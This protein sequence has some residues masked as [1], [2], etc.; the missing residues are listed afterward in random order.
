MWLA[1]VKDIIRLE[2]PKHSLAEAVQ[3]DLSASPRV[4]VL[5]STYQGALYV[6]E[7]L[8]SVLM[9]L[10]AQGTIV[11]R[12]DGS[13]DATVAE[14]AKIADPRIKVILGQNLGFGQSFLT[15]LTLVPEDVDMVMFADQDDV[16]LSNKIARAWEGVRSVGDVPALYGSAQTLVDRHLKSLHV[17]TTPSR[18]PSLANALTENII[19]GCTA[20]INRP[21]F[22]LL[23]RAGVPTGVQFHDWWLYL[24]VSAFGIVVYDD[25]PTLLYRQHGANVIGRRVGWRGHLQG[26][27]KVVTRNDWLGVLL[28]QV[29]AFVEHYGDSLP[30]GI[31]AWIAQHFERHGGETVPRWTLVFSTQRWRQS[32]ADDLALR[33]LLLLHKCGWAAGGK[34]ATGGVSASGPMG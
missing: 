9:Q 32:L 29:H 2:K 26:A 10:P 19:V 22:M 8:L 21:A 18:G 34:Q 20:A 3:S 13:C 25:R 12:D 31:G 7:Q 27:Y 16:W 24:V 15:L 5:M 6:R 17:T 33:I 1:E 23:R 28:G 14:I 30:P 4:V 11:V